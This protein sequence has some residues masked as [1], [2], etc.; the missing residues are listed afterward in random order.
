M[1]SGWDGKAKGA[2]LII[3]DHQNATAFTHWLILSSAYFEAAFF[4]LSSFLTTA[5][6]FSK[7]RISLWA[8]KKPEN[9]KGRSRFLVL[10]FLLLLYFFQNFLGIRLS[11]V[12]QKRYTKISDISH[13]LP[14]HLF[15][16]STLGGG[17]GGPETPSKI[18]SLRTKTGSFYKPKIC[19]LILFLL[20]IF[21]F[22]G[23]R[24]FVFQD[25]EGGA[26]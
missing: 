18:A 11:S 6:K 20:G 19:S 1:N 8:K 13:P 10:V 4:T 3:E 23:K 15:T 12:G 7:L 2:R 21:F 16:P 17:D 14:P 9:G 22:S 25:S 5:S 26:P 24:L